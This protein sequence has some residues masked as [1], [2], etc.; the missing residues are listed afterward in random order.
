MR[1]ISDFFWTLSGTWFFSRMLFSFGKQL[2]Q[3]KGS[4]Q[5]K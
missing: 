3:V 4:V 2:G 5:K 1:R